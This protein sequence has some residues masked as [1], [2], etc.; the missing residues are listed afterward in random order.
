[1][2]ERWGWCS[3][4]SGVIWPLRSSSATSEWSRVSCSSS[5]VAQQVRAAVAH[6]GQADLV[7]AIFA[8]VRVVPIPR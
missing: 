7:A 8:A 2:I 4:A 1:M 6:V 3:A 5:T